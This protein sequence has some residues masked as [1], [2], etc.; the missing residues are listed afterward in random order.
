MWR[1]ADRFLINDTY[2]C[3]QQLAIWSAEASYQAD[4]L[5]YALRQKRDWAELAAAV[6]QNREKAATV[7]AD[8]LGRSANQIKD[9]ASMDGFSSLK[10]VSDLIHEAAAETASSSSEHAY[11]A[12]DR[13][14]E[15]SRRRKGFVKSPKEHR[16]RSK[17]GGIPIEFVFY[18]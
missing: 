9:G 3:N 1:G 16:T 11:R 10:Q 2:A 5:A 6:A 14:D 4:R 7:L 18:P 12:F 13:L 15:S 8:F 17:W